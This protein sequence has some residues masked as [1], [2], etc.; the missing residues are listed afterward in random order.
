M[1]TEYYVGCYDCMVYRDLDKFYELS[2]DVYNRKGM[3]E[4]ATKLKSDTFR[5][6]LLVSFMSKHRTHKCAVFNEHDSE[7]DDFDPDYDE[8]NIDYDYWNCDATE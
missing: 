2:W 7:Y 4:L 3:I 1:G 6:A 8:K 5:L